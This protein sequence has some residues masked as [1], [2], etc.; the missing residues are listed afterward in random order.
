MNALR[1]VAVALVLLA[2]ACDLMAPPSGLAT[3]ENA[4]VGLALRELPRAT[5][6]SLGLPYGLAVVKADAAAAHAGLRMGDV[7]YGVNHS[8]IRSVV[9]FARL[10]A[11]Q[12]PGAPLTLLVRRGATDLYLPVGPGR[13]GRRAT[14]TLLRT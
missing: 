12:P 2:A 5:L 3:I 1:T 9:D 4:S 6:R 8:R 14:D 7:I 10:M 13:S 11:E